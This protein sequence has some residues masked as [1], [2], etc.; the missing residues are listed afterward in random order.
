MPARNARMKW[1]RRDILPNNNTKNYKYTF[2]LLKKF[3]WK[4]CKDEKIQKD[5]FSNINTHACN[6]GVGQKNY[7]C[8]ELRIKWIWK[9][10]VPSIQAYKSLVLLRFM[11]LIQKVILL[12]MYMQIAEK[13]MHA[14]NARMK[15]IRRDI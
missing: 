15:L 6:S 8:K 4:V 2:K 1:I 5:I 7:T 13:T 14:R 11:W 9:N 12:K 10:I 3:T